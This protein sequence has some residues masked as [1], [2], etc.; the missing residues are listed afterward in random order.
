MAEV[1]ASNTHTAVLRRTYS[2]PVRR[3]FDA[4]TQPALLAKWFVPNERWTGA[5]AEIDLRVGGRYRITMRH[6]DGDAFIVGGMY[7]EVTP[8]TKLVFTFVWEH[9]PM[10]DRVGETLVTVDLK[11]HNGN[12]EL[13]LTHEGFVSTEI[14]SEHN[15][16]WSGILEMLQRCLDGV[17]TQA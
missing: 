12:T 16:G 1:G 15:L 9:N 7:K 8:P 11:E 4:W 5:E 13:T 6:S 2:A 10:V 3:V 17:P 14:A